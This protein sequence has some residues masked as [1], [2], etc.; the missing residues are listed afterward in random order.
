M[1]LL[2]DNSAEPGLAL[3]NSIRN[4]HLLAQSGEEDDQLNRV[5]VVR[6]EHKRSLLGLDESDH[7]VQTVLDSVWLLADVLLFLA[8]ADGG[9]LLEQ[10]V[11]LL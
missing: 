8:L 4:S 5:D 1:H 7:V 3:N 2:V 6:D 10:T 9:G 11:F